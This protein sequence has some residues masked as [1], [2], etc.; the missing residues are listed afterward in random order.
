MLLR[1]TAV[2]TRSRPLRERLALIGAKPYIAGLARPLWPLP[3]ARVTASEDG[4]PAPR[5]AD[6]W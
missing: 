6:G 4:R 2:Q 1:L 3:P 5:Y